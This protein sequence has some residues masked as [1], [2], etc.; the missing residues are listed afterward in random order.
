M[1]CLLTIFAIITTFILAFIVP[2]D[3]YMIVHHFNLP[4]MPLWL[5]ISII[6]LFVYG[7]ISLKKEP[8]Y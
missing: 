1:K 2:S 6:C 5:D 8:N 7:V 4:D 3:P